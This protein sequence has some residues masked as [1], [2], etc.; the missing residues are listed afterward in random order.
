MVIDAGTGDGRAVLERAAAEPAALVIGIDAVA[1]S[2]AE[3]SRRAHRRGPHNALF[4][5]AGIEA[6]ATSPLAC[7]AQL[8]TVL[9]PWG[10]LL[11]GVL[12]LDVEALGGVASLVASGGRLEVLASVVPS[13]RV[14][15]LACLDASAEP[16]I[17]V[18]WRG[19]GL[20]LVT[21]RTATTEE[22]VASGS[23]WARRLGDGRPVWRLEG[24][25]SASIAP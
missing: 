5:A 6:V 19:V 1:A 14:D 7:S 2:M 25:R 12:G 10:S 18:A 20:D 11:R 22:I 9:F 3:R 13:D 15:G 8:V 23:R 4:L 24:V 21:F 16:A 17:R